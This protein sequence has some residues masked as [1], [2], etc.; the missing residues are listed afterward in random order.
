[1]NRTPADHSAFLAALSPSDL[2]VVEPQLRDVAL[3]LGNVLC[4]VGERID[5]AYFP[6]SGMV[7]VVAN[8]PEGQQVETGMV[9]RTGVVG[10]AEYPALVC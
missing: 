7:S 4:E 10:S 6:T 8:L 2:G 3:K 9:G 5:Y 1:M